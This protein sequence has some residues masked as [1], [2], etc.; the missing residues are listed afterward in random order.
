MAKQT[1]AVKPTAK[2]LKTKKVVV[3]QKPKKTLK[4]NIPPFI[5]ETAWEV[6]NQVG[7][8]YTVIRSK[9]P[10][11]T[12][13]YGSN[14]MLIG[15]YVGK[16]IEAELDRTQVRNDIISNTVK[17]INKKGII[18]HDAVWLITGRPRVLLFDIKASSHNI[19]ELKFD[20]WAKLKVETRQGNPLIDDAI[21]FGYLVK[22]FLTSL[23]RSKSAP[24][25]IA[26]FHEWQASVPIL[27]LKSEKA[28]V[29]T[30]FTTHAT[31]LGRYLAYNS[32][33]FYDHLPFFDVVKEAKHFG[34]YPEFIIER[35]S[36]KM[37][38]KFT[39]V[40]EVTGN[41]STHI[42]KRK[43]NQILPNGL[44]IKRFVAFHEFQNIHARFKEEINHFVT[45]HFFQSYPFN[46]DKTLYFFTSGRYEFR[47]KGYDMTLQALDKLNQKLKKENSKH[48]IVVFFV[49]R[50]PHHGIK[51]EVLETRALME[52][53]RLNS[54]AI[55][56]QVGKKLFY[57]GTTNEDNRLP[58]LNEFVE[59]YWRIR[60]RRTIQTWKS[61]KK[62]PQVTHNLDDPINDEVLS[63]LENSSLDNGPEQKVK[64]VYHPEF[65]DP[66]N[67][68]F[69]M[70]Y[71]EFVRGC[72]LGIF[73]SYYE[74]W[75]YTPLECMASGLPSITSDLSGFGD[76]IKTNI[77]D[78]E[79]KG[80][81]VINRRKKK[82]QQ[83]VNQLVD[84]LYEFIKQD[85]R[86]RIMQR[87]NTENAS[88]I[89]DWQNLVKYYDKVYKSVVKF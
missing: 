10:A 63:F 41:E 53:I 67:P 50:R 5:F 44:N 80:L 31:I 78:L 59:D 27:Y 15:P 60:Y 28:P 11:M 45:G 85:R 81:F 21:S 24:P 17:R 19:E 75:G 7:G 8:I 74:P 48:T 32:P 23:A 76:Y 13:L 9:T 22:N 71:G 61:A 79:E 84:I 87:N 69:R 20:L 49:T 58:D 1:T 25:I 73:P 38:D 34:I 29:K 68:L 77:P 82:F 18:I 33:H 39:T 56:Q 30:I 40:S 4:Q 16:E 47:N 55:Q 57:A 43:V 3:Q 72:H 12:S 26:H 42:L 70:E 89:F 52:E 88:I 46:L 64:I 2:S 83:S 66:S 51:S 65:I 6:C 35:Y 14:F 54:D 36:A 62:P 86:Q 37:A